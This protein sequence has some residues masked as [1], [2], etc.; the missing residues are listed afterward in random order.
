MFQRA[1]HITITNNHAKLL[2]DAMIM[3]DNLLSA[4]IIAEKICEHYHNRVRINNSASAL[5][6]KIITQ[7][8]GD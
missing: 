1:Y 5:K 7:E 6:T 8:R 2:A 4:G 3:A